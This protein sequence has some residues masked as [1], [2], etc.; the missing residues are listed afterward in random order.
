MVCWGRRVNA[1]TIIANSTNK[2]QQCFSFKMNEFSGG[3]I[4]GKTVAENRRSIS[5]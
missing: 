4:E 5:A 1:F 2:K 3:S